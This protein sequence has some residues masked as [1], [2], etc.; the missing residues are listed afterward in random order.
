MMATL[1]FHCQ[2]IRGIKYLYTIIKGGE[3]IV[4]I[5]SVVNPVCPKCGSHNVRVVQTSQERDIKSVPMGRLRLTLR[6]PVRRVGCND[7]GACCRETL[8]FLPRKHVG[9]TRSLANFV[10]SLRSQMSI[11]AVADWVGLHWETV[12]QI[13]KDYLEKKYKRISLKDVE[14]IGIDEVYL[15]K[16]IGYLTVVRDLVSGDV[17]YIGK[18]RGLEALNGFNARIRRQSSHIKAICMD[19]SGPYG[20]WAKM[21]LPHADV[22]FDHFHVIKLM[23]EKLNTLRRKTLNQA[24]EEMKKEL[25]SKRALL[26]KNEEDL[27]AEALEQLHRIREIFDELGVASSMKECLRRIYRMANS[28]ELARKAFERWCRQALASGIDALKQMAKT[29][30]HRLDGLV[31]YWKH[32]HITNAS[33]EGFNNKIGWLTRQAYGYRDQK[34]L[35]L[36]IF[37]LPHFSIH[38]SL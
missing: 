16:T 29:I 30:T 36:K 19:M 15:G 35:M 13:E 8:P 6:I 21:M 9:Y 1:L 5:E 17:L 33:Q 14:Y 31:A 2:N 28:P 24:D 22:V 25:K 12:K 23:N 18:G 34:F 7:C 11:K 32:D 27:D 38:K 20:A 4:K 26:L 3:L 10:L 37:D